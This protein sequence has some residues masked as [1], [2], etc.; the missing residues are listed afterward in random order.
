[1]VRFL[2][3][4]LA[5]T[6]LLPLSARAQ[7]GPPLPPVV[8][9]VN[10]VEISAGELSAEVRRLLPVSVFHTRVTP[11]KLGE[12][13]HQALNRLIEKELKIQEAKR[14]GIRASKK[15]VKAK[16][17][18]L[19]AAYPSRKAFKKRLKA[20][21]V[22]ET[23]LVREIRRRNV[24][25]KAYQTAVV[26]TI[27][28]TGEDAKV[29]YDTH[30]EKFVEPRQAHV[31][32]IL[33][34]V[35]PLA[36]PD[37]E[38]GIKAKAE[39]II[40]EVAGGLA[41]ADAAKKYSEDETREAGGDLGW[42]HEG[43]LD[44]T[45]NKAIFSAKVGDVVGPFRQFKGYYILTVEGLREARTVP[46]EETRDKLISE[47]HDKALRERTAAWMA[48]LKRK[49]KIDR[50]LPVAK[51]ETAAVGE[52]EPLAPPEGSTAK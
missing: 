25:E 33:L 7:S 39:K 49:S 51:K 48:A 47:L 38:K 10:G 32:E 5:A 20:G 16:L 6:L 19:I 35:Q 24:A 1:M 13:R 42:L 45:S 31:R 52:A 46:F 50:F 43:Q 12:L 28:V 27:K 41:F 15:E 9:R 34:K 17:K 36:T 23:D 22:S 14:L 21:G 40:A 26:E 4:F 44:T 2:W 18:A 37:D 3:I 8:A 11:E 30:P 29:Y